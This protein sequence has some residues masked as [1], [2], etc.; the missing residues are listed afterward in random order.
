M[1]LQYMERCY[2]KKIWMLGSIYG[3]TV[4]VYT[5]ALYSW[6]LYLCCEYILIACLHFVQFSFSL[7]SPSN[8][9]YQKKIKNYIKIWFLFFPIQYISGLYYSFVCQFSFL[10]I[11]ALCISKMM[12]LLC[13]ISMSPL[14][15]PIFLYC[16]AA[17]GRG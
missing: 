9:F 3:N 15:S 6:Q 4:F 8:H 12:S 10:G 2:L 17:G 5:S 16:L 11:L 7:C 14:S 13:L 1:T